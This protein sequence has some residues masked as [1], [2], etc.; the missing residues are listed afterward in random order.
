MLL[1]L[2]PLLLL[3]LPCHPLMCYQC[4]SHYDY[5]CSD[6]FLSEGGEARSGER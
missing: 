5:Q 1:L 4:N 6:P 3:L 2:L